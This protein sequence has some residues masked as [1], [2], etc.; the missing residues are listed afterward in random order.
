MEA[1]LFTEIYQ[2]EERTCTATA[3]PIFH[4]LY[5]NIT[6]QL[7]LLHFHLHGLAVTKSIDRARLRSTVINGHQKSTFGGGQGI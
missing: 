1:K 6:T 7:K 3:S 5:S 4:L 2:P